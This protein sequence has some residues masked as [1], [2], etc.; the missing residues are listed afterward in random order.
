MAALL[1]STAIAILVAAATEAR[2]TLPLQIEDGTAR[3][4]FVEV[5]GS[6]D[7]ATVGQSFGPPMPRPAK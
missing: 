3:T 1:R 6:I 4:V 5:E 7:L 2:A